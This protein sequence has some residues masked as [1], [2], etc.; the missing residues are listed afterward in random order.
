MNNVTLIL[1]GSFL[2]VSMLMTWHRGTVTWTAPLSFLWNRNCSLRKQVS[3]CEVYHQFR[4]TA[5]EN[6]GQWEI[7]LRRNRFWSWREYWQASYWDASSRHKRRGRRRYDPFKKCLGSAVEDVGGQRIL[8]TLWNYYNDNLVF[9]FTNTASL[10]KRVEPTKGNVISTASKMYD[11]LGMIHSVAILIPQI[12]MVIKSTSLAQINVHPTSTNKVL[13]LLNRLNKSKAAGLD[14]ISARLIRECAD[15]ICIPIRDIFNQSVS[16]GIF[17]D[18]WK[19]AKVTPLFKK[20]RSGR[21]K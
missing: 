10:A 9:D 19:C 21:L 14:K 3:I 1:P 2:K 11:P 4:R 20:R 16:Q 5:G 13:S 6:W 18:D 8:V 15:L 7:G 12:V 17:P